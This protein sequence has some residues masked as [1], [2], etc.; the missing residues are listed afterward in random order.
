MVWFGGKFAC[1]LET[2]KEARFLHA[3]MD[4]LGLALCP[5]QSCVAYTDVPDCHSGVFTSS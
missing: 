4:E 1:I 3:A 5:N 2:G